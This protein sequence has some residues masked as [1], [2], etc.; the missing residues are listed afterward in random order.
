MEE[1]LK[2][3]EL[4]QKLGVDAGL[5]AMP[6]GAPGG[7]GGA[8][9]GPGG[10][11]GAPGGSMIHSNTWGKEG[12]LKALEYLKQYAKEG[13]SFVYDG[14]GDCWLMLAVLYQLRMCDLAT[15][16]GAFGKNLP[17]KAYAVGSTPKE[18]QP[19]YFDVKEEGDNILITANLDPD[20]TPFDM[21]FDQIVAPE[22]PE[23]K[24][25]YVRLNGRH[26][27]FVFP[28]SLTYGDKAKAIFMD[29][30]DDCYCSVSNTSE[31]SVGDKVD[32]PF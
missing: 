23:G 22:I 14:H 20:K 19:V 31:V 18:G 4:A 30:A 25:I 27:L 24:N 28:L 7:P 11:G 8:P 26:L 15:Y 1:I 17:L 3:S 13:E 10:P 9:G 21:P 2:F 29:Y 12:G 6:G 16:I 5:P 32:C